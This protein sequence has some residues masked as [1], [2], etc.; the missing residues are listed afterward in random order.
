MQG[1]EPIEHQHGLERTEWRGGGHPGNVATKP[2]AAK[3]AR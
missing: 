3:P 2:K 1:G